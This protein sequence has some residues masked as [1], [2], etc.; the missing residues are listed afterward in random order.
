[1][2]AGTIIRPVLQRER[3]GLSSSHLPAP[4]Y[5]STQS[6]RTLTPSESSLT[7]KCP[8][9]CSPWACRVAARY[10]LWALWCFS[11]DSRISRALYTVE[12][13]RLPMVFSFFF[14]P[15]PQGAHPC[16]PPRFAQGDLTVTT[17]VLIMDILSMLECH[18]WSLY[19]SVDQST[20]VS[21]ACYCQRN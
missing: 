3:E 6:K 13:E 17:R 7:K 16:R 11:N 18:G 5:T 2:S 19:A 12:D 10:V 9:S 21:R 8:L 1:M 20:G 14:E 15:T 4:T